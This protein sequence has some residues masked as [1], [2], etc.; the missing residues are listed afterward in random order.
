MKVCSKKMDEESDWTANVKEAEE[1]DIRKVKEG[2][3]RRWEEKRS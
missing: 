2:A 1:E 3:G